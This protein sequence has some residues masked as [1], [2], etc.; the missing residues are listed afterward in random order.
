[1]N[2]VAGKIKCCNLNENEKEEKNRKYNRTRKK[3]Q[4][5]KREIMKS[6]NKR[7]SIETHL[8]E[9]IINKYEKKR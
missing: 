2:E 6:K 3:T 1:M 5:R 4:Q 9:K 7:E 8:K